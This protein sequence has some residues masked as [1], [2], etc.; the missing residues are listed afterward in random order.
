MSQEQDIINVSNQIQEKISFI[1]TIRKQ[2]GI[3]GKEKAKKETEYEKAISITIIKLKNGVKFRVED[4]DVLNPP[5]TVIKDIAKGICW[6]EK[7]AMEESN[8]SY[9]S[10]ITNISALESELS[11]LQSLHKY[12]Q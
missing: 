7:L 12:L 9:K 2:I 1:E 5:T 11:A 3:R 10:A 8:M 4:Q 6:K